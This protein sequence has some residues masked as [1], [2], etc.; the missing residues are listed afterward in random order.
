MPGCRSRQGD[1]SVS[2][3]KQCGMQRRT[4]LFDVPQIP[5]GLHPERLGSFFVRYQTRNVIISLQFIPKSVI[6]VV[7]VPFR[8][9]VLLEILIEVNQNMGG[10]DHYSYLFPCPVLSGTSLDNRDHMNQKYANFHGYILATKDLRTLR[11][12]WI[13]GISRTKTD[14]KLHF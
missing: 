9:D 14:Q 1:C 5:F 7:Y 11:I 4:V 10:Y 6:I 12:S 13:S 2:A 3:E 8:G